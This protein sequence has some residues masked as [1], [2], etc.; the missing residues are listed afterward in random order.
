MFRNNFII[1]LLYSTLCYIQPIQPFII[2]YFALCYNLIIIPYN[3]VL[4]HCN[5]ELDCSTAHMIVCQ[6]LRI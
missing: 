1:L 4:H 3:C 6:K 5:L 2:L